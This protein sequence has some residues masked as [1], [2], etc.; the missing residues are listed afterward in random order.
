MVGNVEWDWFKQFLNWTRWLVVG[1]ALAFLAVR[2]LQWS[3]TL[4]RHFTG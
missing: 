3:T 1:V 4:R 2:T